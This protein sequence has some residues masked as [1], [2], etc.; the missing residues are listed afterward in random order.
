MN[1]YIAKGANAAL[2]KRLVAVIARLEAG[3]RPRYGPDDLA[4]LSYVR[5]ELDPQRIKDTRR[6]D[7]TNLGK[8]HVAAKERLAHYETEAHDGE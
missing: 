5:D 3:E 6:E 7:D 8:L 2:K 4:V 1:T